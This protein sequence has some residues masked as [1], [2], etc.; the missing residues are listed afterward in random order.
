MPAILHKIHAAKET[1]AKT[2]EIWG[3]GTARREFMYATDLADLIWRAAGDMAGL[4]DL[5]N[6]GLG[7]DHAINDY[8]AI[9]ARVLG[10][11]GTFTHD[12]DRPVGMKQK[13]CDASRAH[14]WGWRSETSLEEG[15]K[16]TWDFYLTEYAQ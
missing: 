13:L 14:A 3:D 10:W 4:P 9:A 7:H 16:R 1:G 15:L 8:Y 6:A 5:M 2:V 11:E 12:L